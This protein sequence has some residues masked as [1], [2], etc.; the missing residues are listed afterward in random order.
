LPHGNYRGAIE[1]ISI[2]TATATSLTGWSE[3][4]FWRR[5]A[6]GS[7]KRDT[8]IAASKSML[9]FESIKLYSS[10]PTGSDDKLLMRN[11]NVPINLEIRT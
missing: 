3:R 4:T 5:F 2:A 8:S 9:D 10:L 7:V 11:E 6:D 1:F